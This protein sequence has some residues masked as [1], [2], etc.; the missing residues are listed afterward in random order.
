MDLIKIAEEAFSTKK[1]HPALR[2]ATQLPLLTVSKKV[3]R[4]VSRTTAA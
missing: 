2:V 3:T 4:N 1:E